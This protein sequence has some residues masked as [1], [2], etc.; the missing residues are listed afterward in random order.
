MIVHKASVV[1]H[2]RF[3]LRTFLTRSFLLL[4]GSLVPHKLISAHGRDFRLLLLN[5]TIY[6]FLLLNSTRTLLVT[7][8]TLVTHVKQ[9][10]H[11]LLVTLVIQHAHYLLT[12]HT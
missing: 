10:A 6:L 9:H 5:G 12:C 1:H 11:Y 8:V 2:L 7:F 4:Y 3:V